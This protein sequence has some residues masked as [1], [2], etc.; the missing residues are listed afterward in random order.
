MTRRIIPQRTRFFL[1]VEG[2]GEQSFITW[3]GRIAGQHGLHVALDCEP[4]GGGGYK[5]MLEK[6]V[7]YRRRKERSK[8]KASVLLLDEDR[9]TRDDGWTIAQLKAK[10]AKKGISVCMQI[11]N[12]EGLLLRMMPGKERLQPPAPTAHKQLV[13]LWPEYDKPV[14]A[15][16]L[17]SKFTLEDLHRVAQVDEELRA[18][19]VIIG[20]I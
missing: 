1:A 4:L 16:M 10:A 12:Q 6:A 15:Q 2:Q 9:A 17:A 8:A 13:A 19:L 20:L 11:P 3:L 5:S 18:L 7:R 14:D